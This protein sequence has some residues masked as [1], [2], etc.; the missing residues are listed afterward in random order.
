M[1]AQDMT[2]AL[3]H[4]DPDFTFATIG[5]DTISFSLESSKRRKILKFQLHPSRMQL[6]NNRNHMFS[7]HKHP[8]YDTNIK[9]Y[10]KNKP[11]RH[12]TTC[13]NLRGWSHQQQGMQHLRGC[14][15]GRA[16]FPRE[17]CP[18]ISWT[19]VALVVQLLL[20]KPIGQKHQ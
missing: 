3:K 18:N 5:D 6:I 10:F 17:I 13:H 2:D 19:W 20:V 7:Q 11:S 4:P 1:A 9:R 15:Q 8:H 16:N 14:Q 12:P